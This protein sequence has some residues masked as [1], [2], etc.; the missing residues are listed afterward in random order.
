MVQ[1]EVQNSLNLWKGEGSDVR[2]SHYASSLV[3]IGRRRGAQR[4]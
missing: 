3:F 2:A 1:V 4:L